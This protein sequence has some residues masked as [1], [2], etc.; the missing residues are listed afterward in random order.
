MAAT[1]QVTAMTGVLQHCEAFWAGLAVPDATST[2]GDY[3]RLRALGLLRRTCKDFAQQMCPLETLRR[4]IP[5]ARDRPLK[6]RAAMHLL[7]LTSDALSRFRV[8]PMCGACPFSGK[9]RRKAPNRRDCVGWV[10]DP[11]RE[12]AERFTQSGRA[13]TLGEAMAIAARRHG[14]AIAALR[15]GVRRAERLRGLRAERQI[16]RFTIARARHARQAKLDAFLRARG[17]EPPRGLVLNLN[18]SVARASSYVQSIPPDRLQREIVSYHARYAAFILEF[19]GEAQWAE[20]ADL[21]EQRQRYIATVKDKLAALGL[22]Q[23]GPRFD[24]FIDSCCEEVEV[25]MIQ[26]YRID[27]LI[28]DAPM[29]YERC[30]GDVLRMADVDVDRVSLARRMFWARVTNTLP[31]SSFITSPTPLTQP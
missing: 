19:S 1:L 23:S 16:R 11:D 30:L 20:L 17:L 31:A 25:S 28:R 24:H 22:E 13:L 3:A 18:C 26:E 6:I 14:G 7:A 4:F 21:L 10:P 5:T 29:A 2:Q 9:R 12:V 15:Q 8:I 27:A